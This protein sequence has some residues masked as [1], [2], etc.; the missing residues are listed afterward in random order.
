MHGGIEEMRG[1]PE[2]GPHREIAGNQQPHQRGVIAPGLHHAVEQAEQRQCR[3]QH[4]RRDH[5]QPAAGIERRRQHDIAGRECAAER[6][7]NADIGPAWMIEIASVGALLP[8]T[9]RQPSRAGQQHGDRHEPAPRPRRAARGYGS[10]HR[11][12]RRRRRCSAMRCGR[13]IRYRDR[14]RHVSSG[15]ST[16]CRQKP[17]RP[18]PSRRSCC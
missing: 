11:I 18:A 6:G 7:R 9:Q 10:D 8:Q 12:R 13:A 5:Q 15:R 4:H 16:P 17:A 14:A 3:R 1:N 2:A